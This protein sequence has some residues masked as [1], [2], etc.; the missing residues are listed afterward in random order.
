MTYEIQELIKK[1]EK[2]EEISKRISQQQ[3]KQVWIDH[4]RRKQARSVQPVASKEV[5]QHQ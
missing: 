4:D 3:E 2:A 5:L 1:I